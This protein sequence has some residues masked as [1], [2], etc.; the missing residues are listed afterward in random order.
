MLKEDSTHDAQLGQQFANAIGHTSFAMWFPHNA[1]LSVSGGVLT[2]ATDSSFLRD[3]VRTNMDDELRRAAK[4]II[5]GNGELRY[6]VSEPKQVVRDTIATVPSETSAIGSQGDRVVV[7]KSVANGIANGIAKSCASSPATPAPSPYPSKAANRGSFETFV[8]GESNRFAFEVARQV[9]RRGTMGTPVTLL[10][11]CGSGKSHLLAAIR[12][13]Y[14]CRFPKSRTLLITAEQFTTGFLGALNGGGLPNFRHKHRGV[15]L[16]IIDNLPFF[17]GKRATI[18]ELQYTIDSVLS[19]GG[20]VVL[21]SH[22]PLAELS[23]LGG[24]L[25]SRCASGLTCDLGLPDAEARREII[26]QL[27][28]RHETPV[29]DDVVG[30]LAIGLATGVREIMG[31]VNRLA[32]QHRLLGDVI[33]RSLAERVVGQANR[34][35]RRPVKLDDIQRVVCDFFGVDGKALRSDDRHKSVSQPR[36][37]AMWL[38]RKYT[39]SAWREIGTYFGGRSHSTVISAHRRIEKQLNSTS[40]TRIAGQP[41][42]LQEAIERLESALRTG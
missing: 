37:L 11:D 14:R 13:D 4:Q 5:G 32:T 17:V 33:D 35:A 1:R 21:A 36:M 42:Q 31:V 16:L 30:V 6:V 40:E 28:A 20:Q 15:D 7:E 12:D 25:I 39:Q 38:A 29:D 34:H 19:E 9:A 18:E 3:L 23:Q 27:F 22:K 41:W 2:I 24:E 10:G 26:S 8:I